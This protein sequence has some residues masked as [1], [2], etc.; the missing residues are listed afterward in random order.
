MITTYQ[1]T[2]IEDFESLQKGDVIIVRWHKQFLKSHKGSKELMA[3]RV[4]EVKKDQHEIVCQ[5]KDNHYFNYHLYLGLDENKSNALEVV[6]VKDG[7]PV[8]D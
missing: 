3:Y 8:E 6:F 4:H 2:T 7:E 5:L 1:P